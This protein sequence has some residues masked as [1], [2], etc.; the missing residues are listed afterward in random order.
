M[1][2]DNA[3]KIALA[4]LR[5]EDLHITCQHYDITSEGFKQMHDFV[6]D[7]R[8]GIWCN[9]HVVK[10]NP[11]PLDKLAEVFVIGNDAGNFQHEFP[12]LPACQ[13]IIKAMLQLG[14]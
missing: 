5:Q 11:M 9:W 7:F 14:Y 4:Q 1:N 6:V 8:L 13:Q 3:S 10:G 12:T 2:I